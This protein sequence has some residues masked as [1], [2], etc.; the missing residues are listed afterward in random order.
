MGDLNQPAGVLDNPNFKRWFG[1]SKIVDSSGK[2]LVVYHGTNTEFSEFR[3][4]EFGFH[5]GSEAQAKSCGEILMPVY[6]SIKN[7]ILFDTDF[8]SWCEE[9][10]APYLVDRQVI[11]QEEADS[12][13]LQGLLMSKGYD[14]YT[15]QN[16]YEGGGYS[17]A[18]F[19]PEQIKSAYSNKGSF[20]SLNPDI[21]R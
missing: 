2:P 11:S 15:Y 1:E 16:G 17:Y 9:D 3:Y 5:F 20:D 6:L 13:D 12:G 14:G 7:P 21:T 4:G 18:V 8:S 19:S 10:I